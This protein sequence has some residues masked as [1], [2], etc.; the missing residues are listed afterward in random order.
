M[1]FAVGST[2][3]VGDGEAKFHAADEAAILQLTP[4]YIT[5]GPEWRG[6]VHRALRGTFVPSYDSLIPKGDLRRPAFV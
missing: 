6:R 1:S 2:L 4:P 3:S 5:I